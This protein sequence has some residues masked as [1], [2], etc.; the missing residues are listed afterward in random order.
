[1]QFVVRHLLRSLDA[2]SKKCH[3]WSSCSATAYSSTR[4]LYSGTVRRHL[5][6]KQENR[7]RVR[8]LNSATS[9]LASHIPYECADD[10]SH[11]SHLALPF[12]NRVIY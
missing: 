11:S 7:R 2:N 8:P 9:V 4:H 6:R 3:A 10:S 1:M 12:P 5:Q